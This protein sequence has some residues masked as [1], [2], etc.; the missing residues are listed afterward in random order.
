VELNYSFTKIGAEV[1]RRNSERT[2]KQKHKV[3]KKE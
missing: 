2:D 3:R 1:R